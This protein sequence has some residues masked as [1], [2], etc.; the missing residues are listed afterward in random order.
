FRYKR[1]RRVTPMNK[2]TVMIS[3]AGGLLGTE[4][5]AQLLKKNKFSIVAMS[6]QKDK[7]LTKYKNTNVQVVSNELWT[8]ELRGI[9]IDTLIN[10][11]FPRSSKPEEL[12]QGI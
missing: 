5:I 3:G 9:Q 1:T 12:A 6:S 11:A 4:L 10:C 7:L 2:Q 8:K